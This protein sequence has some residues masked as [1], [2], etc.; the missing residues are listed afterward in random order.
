MWGLG[1]Y[2]QDEWKATR[3]LKLTFALRVERN[4]NPVCQINCFSNPKGAFYTLPSYQAA[5]AGQDPGN[6][7]YSSDLNYGKHQAYPGVDKAVISPR[8]GFS[9]DLRNNG[10]TVLSG[11]AGIF[12]DNPAAG[13]VDN[14]LGLPGNPPVSV[15]FR[16]RPPCVEGP[17]P[18]APCG[19]LPFDPNG[20]QKTFQAAASA[21]SITSSYNTIQSQL[22]PLGVILPSPAINTLLG[23]IKAPQWTEWNF[24][25]Q[26]ELNRTTV[27]L[28]NYVGNHGARIYY[29]NY[30][31]NAWDLGALYG[32]GCRNGA[33]SNCLFFNGAV[34]GTAGGPDYIYGSVTETKSGAISNYN[35]LT[36]S[37]RKQ[38]S[39]WVMGH[40]NYTWSHNIDEESNGGVFTAG[41]DSILA[42][43]SPVSLRADNYGNSDYDI[44]HSFN[45]DFVISPEFHKTG[46][47]RFLTEGWQ[48]SGKAFVRTGLPFEVVDNNL[49]GVLENNAEGTIPATITGNVQPGSC[50]KSSASVAGTATPC[51][52]Q[53]AVLDTIDNPW[54]NT[55]FPTQRRNQYRGP[56]YF[57]MDMNL[58]KGFKFTEHVNA[59]L[60]VQAFNVFNH[61]NFGLPDNGYSDSTFGQI[62]GMTGTPTS[63]YGVFLGF[64]SSVRVVQLSAKVVF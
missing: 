47:M 59:S 35:G 40:V 30:W 4:S 32:T 56:H 23:T 61:P 36:V 29:E 12:Y 63:P 7:P 42:Q 43:I 34:N 33:T 60:G 5:Q 45:G 55:A 22:T 25:V 52:L 11:G 64:D 31:P 57:D 24:S 38:F 54:A 49:F 37:L 16:V 18:A 44:R 17:A 10:K 26:Q 2:G 50:G 21:F 9:W 27:L 28:L 53:S 8:L 15:T 3:N 51:L 58:F 1:V 14:I 62:T 48:L 46:A 41:G 19:T 13:V 39:H 20:A 6:T